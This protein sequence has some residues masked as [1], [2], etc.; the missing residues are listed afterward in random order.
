MAQLQRAKLTNQRLE[1]EKAEL[2]TEI[3]KYKGHSLADN[4]VSFHHIFSK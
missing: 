2:L 3:R 1:D 4:F